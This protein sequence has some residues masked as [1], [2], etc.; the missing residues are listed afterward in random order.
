[1][2]DWTVSRSTKRRIRS[3]IVETLALWREIAARPDL[4]D[5]QRKQIQRHID[6]VA[7]RIKH[8]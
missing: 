2:M 4:T 8:R 5:A 1:M 3:G 7:Q 6:D